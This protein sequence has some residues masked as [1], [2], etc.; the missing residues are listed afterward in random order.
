[1]H[2]RPRR[3]SSRSQP[4]RP[5]GYVVRNVASLVDAPRIK[6][7][8]FRTLSAEEARA[9]LRAAEG[10]RFEALYVVALT[11]G[12]RQGEL[13]GLQW[14]SVDL[15]RQTLAVRG[16]LER[17][18]KTLT[19]GEPKTRTSRRQVHLTPAAVEAL[20]QHRVRQHE[21]RLAVGSAWEDNELVFCS[22]IGTP[23]SASNLLNRSFRRL[24]ERAGIEPIRFHDLRHTAATLL[25]EQG[26]HPKIVS[27][28]LGHSTIAITLDLYS[29]VTSA[30]HK[31]AA[32]A[33]EEILRS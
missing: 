8:S 12:M 26:M 24:L 7:H 32:D 5:L 19:I 3:A 33:M 6:R 29:H 4:C 15:K 23:V 30:M 17:G 1:M 2:Q 21:E 14:K 22:E 28:M 27:E 13:L 11:T 10:D 9:L 18:V 25:L 16:S 31:Q 20:R